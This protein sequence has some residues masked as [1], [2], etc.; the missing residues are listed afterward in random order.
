[1]H[2]PQHGH[3]DRFAPLSQLNPQSSQNHLAV[4]ILSSDPSFYCSYSPPL[5]IFTT[6]LNQ[7]AF[8]KDF[9]HLFSSTPKPPLI[10]CLQIV[11]NPVEILWI[12]C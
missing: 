1:M 2:P 9:L 8:V 12:P 7:G 11:H 5:S 6:I 10:N 4:S 3:S